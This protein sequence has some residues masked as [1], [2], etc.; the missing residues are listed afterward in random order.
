MIVL[1]VTPICDSIRIRFS[2]IGKG[3]I[4]YTF[5]KVR[6]Y[7]NRSHQPSNI[8]HYSNKN[9]S[10]GIVLRFPKSG[11]G[12]WFQYFFNTCNLFSNPHVSTA[13]ERPCNRYIRICIN[14]TNSWECHRT[15][16]SRE[17]HRFLHFERTFSKEDSMFTNRNNF[18]T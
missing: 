15:E 1:V 7:T 12:R 14:L 17:Q 2:F 9:S 18:I 4:G 3:E 8:F 10:L 13:F 11:I 6:L 5:K 16:S